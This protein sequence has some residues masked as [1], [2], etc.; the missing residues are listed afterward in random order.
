MFSKVCRNLVETIYLFKIYSFVD[1]KLNRDSDISDYDI[2]FFVVF[3]RQAIIGDI[4]G[5]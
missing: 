2:N 5:Q 3:P 1:Q 4:S